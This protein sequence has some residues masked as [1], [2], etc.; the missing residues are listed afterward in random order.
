[1][2]P[3]ARKGTRLFWEVK[4]VRKALALTVGLIGLLFCLA[5]IML[6]KWFLEGDQFGAPLYLVSLYTGILL[7]IQAFEIEKDQERRR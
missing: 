5:S 1:L 3:K 4:E 7:I 6:A 2:D